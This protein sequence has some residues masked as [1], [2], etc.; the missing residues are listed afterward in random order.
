M[1]DDYYNDDDN[2]FSEYFLSDK[3]NEQWI[4]ETVKF[5]GLQKQSDI[6][7]PQKQ[8]ETA[9]L[10]SPPTAHCSESVSAPYI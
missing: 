1:E 10:H 9:T 2:F 5:N 7:D 8:S 3:S 4:T 6:N